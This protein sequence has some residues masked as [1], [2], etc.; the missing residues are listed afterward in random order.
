MTDCAGTLVLISGSDPS[1]GIGGHSSYVRLHGLAALRAGYTPHIFCVGLHEH[2]SC[3]EFGMVHRVQSPYQPYRNVMLHAHAPRLIRG[4]EK[5]LLPKKGCHLLHGFSG[6]SY[7]GAVV[8]ERLKKK[9]VT[10]VPIASSYDTLLNVAR[11]KRAGVGKAHGLLERMH[12]ECEFLWKK[13]V[14]DRYERRGYISA[15]SVLVNYESVRRI[16]V[17][18]YGDGMESKIRLAPY[19]SEGALRENGRAAELELPESIS[20]LEFEDA[21]LLLSVSRHDPRKGLDVFLHALA[22]LRQSGN[23]FRACLVGGGPLL[24]SHRQLAR[25]LGLG[26]TVAIPGFVAD[27]SAYLQHAN[28]FVLPSLEEGSGS[29]SLIE[30]LQAGVAVVASGV[31]GI[32]EDVTDGYDALLVPP[33]NVE[34]LAAALRRAIM[35]QELRERLGQNGRETFCRR[36]SA[37]RFIAMLGYFYS[38]ALNS[39]LPLEFY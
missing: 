2:E 36:F 18:S 13:F 12:A 35:D 17:S 38:E 9:N 37:D 25:S 16:L 11:A 4:I 24:A 27:V 28:L 34:E 6:W 32:P 5:F 3:T 31:D 8:A 15:K 33:N 39:A 10:A 7:V 21:P 1:L 19:T 30:A 20:D 29:L 23:R 22:R 14:L 26:G